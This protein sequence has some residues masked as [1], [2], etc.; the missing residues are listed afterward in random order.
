[1]ETKPTVLPFADSLNGDLLWAGLLT[2]V[3]VGVLYYFA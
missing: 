2:A 3:S 1:M